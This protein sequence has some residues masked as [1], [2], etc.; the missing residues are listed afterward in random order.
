MRAG[1]LPAGAP[2]AV[3]DRV[4]GAP[5][6]AGCGVELRVYALLRVSGVSRSRHAAAGVELGKCGGHEQVEDPGE[7]LGVT[8]DACR[9]DGAD[10]GGHQVVGANLR[11]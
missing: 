9:G 8:V 11:P 10:H 6:A 3:D 7:L 2:G 4:G 5:P 1:G